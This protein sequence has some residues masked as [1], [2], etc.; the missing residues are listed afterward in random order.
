MQS[1]A[2]KYLNACFIG[3]KDKNTTV[4]KYFGSAIGHLV[5]I[6]KV[7]LTFNFVTSPILKIKFIYTGAIYY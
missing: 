1:I 7:Q 6:A 4:R 5:G 2:G 3:L